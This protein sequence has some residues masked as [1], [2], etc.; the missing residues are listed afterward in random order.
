[1]QGQ[2]ENDDGIRSGTIEARII[3][4]A[5]INKNIFDPLEVER[6]QVFRAGHRKAID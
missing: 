1:L 3:P 4:D 2:V 6:P 5:V